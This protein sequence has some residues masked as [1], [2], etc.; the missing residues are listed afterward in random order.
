M[1]I[2]DGAPGFTSVHAT[3]SCEPARASRAKPP[4]PYNDVIRAKKDAINRCAQDHGAP[5]PSARV[6]I[7]VATDGRTK[8][9]TLDPAALNSTP[10][11]TCIRNVLQPSMFPRARDEKQ[12]AVTLKPT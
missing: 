12:V 3:T 8:S 5:P 10:L 4:D 2:A 11:G 6:V 7:V 1:R 9:V